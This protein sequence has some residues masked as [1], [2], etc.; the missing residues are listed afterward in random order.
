MRDENSISQ[1]L[2]ERVQGLGPFFQSEAS[3]V[4]VSGG[5]RS[6]GDKRAFQIF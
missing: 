1:F 3:H 4:S 6:F 5:C 2:F